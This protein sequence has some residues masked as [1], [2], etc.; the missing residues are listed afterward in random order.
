MATR[1][2]RS[3]STASTI[4]SHQR[5][6]SRQ[7]TL[8]ARSESTPFTQPQHDMMGWQLHPAANAHNVS[9]IPYQGPY[10]PVDQSLR[11]DASNI[12]YGQPPPS[13]DVKPGYAPPPATAAVPMPYHS[14]QYQGMAPARLQSPTAFSSIE[15]AGDGIS[16][17]EA[18]GPVEGARRKK[19]SATSAANDVE[20]RRLFRENER[21]DLHEVASQVAKD[22]KGPKSEKSKQI[23]GMLW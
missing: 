14:A 21:R 3:H 10:M 6:K 9:G 19:G 18:N 8:S 23:F 7:S 4:S 2:P 16:Q 5:P 13:Q 1:S 12:A 20:L 17:E 22:D 15:P 11:A